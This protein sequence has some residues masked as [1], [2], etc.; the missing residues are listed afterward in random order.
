M[1]EKMSEARSENPLWDQIEPHFHQALSNL[2]PVDREAVLLR[3]AQAQSFGEVGAQLGVSE[4]TARMRVSR[5]VEKIRS[6]LSK[7]GIAVP[8]AILAAL[9]IEKSATASPTDLIANLPPLLLS[10]MPSG[11]MS[12]LQQVVNDSARQMAFS[13]LLIPAI[14]VTGL[15]FAGVGGSLYSA[16][17]P[18]RLDFSHGMSKLES[19]AGKWSGEMQY[20]DSSSKQ[21]QKYRTDLNIHFDSKSSK[22]IMESGYPG[23]SQI[24]KYSIALN[25]ITGSAFVNNIGT[26]PL[27]AI[28][29]LYL[30]RDGSALF[31][32]KER[33]T[34]SDLRVTLTL[35]GNSLNK[36]EEYRKPG[37]RNF[38]LRNRFSLKK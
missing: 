8:S 29:E 7:A 17:L 31:W 18:V 25:R 3:F 37:E 36:T 2:K 27:N 21:L 13:K 22:L 23:I 24:D 11:S 38:H 34:E 33:G 15:L 12:P 19:F 30:A 9:L 20:E 1:A 26:Y 5:A 32:G 28:G 6:T 16:S 4:N 35:K 10:A 14:G